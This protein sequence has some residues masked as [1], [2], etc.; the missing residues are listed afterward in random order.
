M[1]IPQRISLEIPDTLSQ[2]WPTNDFVWVFLE[3][4]AKNCIVGMLLNALLN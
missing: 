4:I 2:W 3:I 1:S